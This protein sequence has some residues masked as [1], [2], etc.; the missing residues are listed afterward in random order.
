MCL[1]G[2][3]GLGALTGVAAP[4][5][6]DIKRRTDSGTLQSGITLL[7]LDLVNVQELLVLINVKW[8]AGQHLALIG[9]KFNNFVI[10]AG[11]RYATVSINQ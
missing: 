3:D 2:Q 6:A 7:T 5:A 11:N 8:G 10:E 9:R 4:D 1:A